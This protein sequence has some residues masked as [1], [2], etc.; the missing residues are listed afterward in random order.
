MK[1][2][3]L[4][5][6]LAVLTSGAGAMAQQKPAA[7]ATSPSPAATPATSGSPMD[8]MHMHGAPKPAATIASVLDRQI[9]GY[10][11]N[12]V[13]AAEAM[14]E[15]KYNFTPTSLNIPGAAYKDVRT[16]AQLVKHTATANYRFWSVIT[17]EPMPQNIKGPNGPDELTKK[18]DIIK[19]LKD[20]F[21]VGHRAAKSLTPENALEEVPFFH[22][23]QARLYV[24]TGT[25]IHAADEYGQIVEYLRMN[26]IVP[27]AS[28]PK[29]P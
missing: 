16:F 27:P 29:Q 14:P 11:T 13:E 20:S 5:C 2:F 17:G 9:G 4:F 28:R 23:T 22:G 6:L 26:G 15:D 18:A 21:V 10:E 7:P 12:L 24:M 8:H 3:S 1:H 25:L 19:F